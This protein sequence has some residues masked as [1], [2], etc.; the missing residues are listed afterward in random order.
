MNNKDIGINNINEVILGF[1]LLRLQLQLLISIWIHLRPV[2]MF[3]GTWL[4]INLV[5]TLKKV[6]FL[7]NP[8]VWESRAI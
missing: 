6:G 5:L 7:N 8:N 3:L 2:F 1:L 4:L